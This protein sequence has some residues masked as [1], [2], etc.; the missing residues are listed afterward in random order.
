MY[1][2]VWILFDDLEVVFVVIFVVGLDNIPVGIKSRGI[3]L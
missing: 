1:I 2:S 3:T